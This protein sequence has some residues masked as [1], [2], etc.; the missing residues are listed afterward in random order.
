MLKNSRRLANPSGCSSSREYRTCISQHGIPACLTYSISEKTDHNDKSEQT[1][2]LTYG[3]LSL[4]APQLDVGAALRL[5]LPDLGMGGVAKRP[6]G[7]PP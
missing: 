3:R 5:L 6:T 7:P 1:V 4:A 2:Q